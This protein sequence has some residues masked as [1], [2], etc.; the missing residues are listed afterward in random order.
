MVFT[1]RSTR[2]MLGAPP[3]KARAAEDGVASLRRGSVFSNGTRSFSSAPRDLH[4]LTTQL[5]TS[6]WFDVGVHGFLDGADP[7]FVMQRSC[8][9]QHRPLRERHEDRSCNSASP[10]A[11][12]P[13]RAASFGF[14]PAQIAV[15]HPE[16]A[17]RLELVGSLT[18]AR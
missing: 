11:R 2:S 16:K 4:S 12:V 6:A 15:A 7:S 1:R 18:A 17:R 8:R 5:Y 13:K 9:Q 3:N 10:A 14:Q